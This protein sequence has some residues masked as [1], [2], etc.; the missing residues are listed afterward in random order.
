MAAEDKYL[1]PDD[2]RE[3]QGQGVEE[4]IEKIENMI[5]DWAASYD[6]ANTIS[7]NFIPKDKTI[8]HFREMGF[9]VERASQI[10]TQKEGD[11]YYISW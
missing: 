10:A 9:K 4:E 3:I 5:R 1:T 8:E 2:V 7:I 11:E 6:K